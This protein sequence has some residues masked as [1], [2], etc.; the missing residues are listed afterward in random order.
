MM[1]VVKNLS[2]NAGDIITG[3][4]P[5]VMKIM[6]RGHSNPLQYSCLED[7]MDR[8]AWRAAVQGVARHWTGLK[9]LSMHT[10]KCRKSQRRERWRDPS[11]RKALLSTSHVSSLHIPSLVNSKNFLSAHFVFSN[12]LVHT[13]I[14]IFKN[15]I[16]SS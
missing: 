6:E 7:V 16:Q 2:A 4:N 5:W 14:F 1:P 12:L 9:R 10:C 8:G 3:F 15:L 13:I 11:D